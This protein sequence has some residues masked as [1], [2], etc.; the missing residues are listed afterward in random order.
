MLEGPEEKLDS[1][2]GLAMVVSSRLFMEEL[3]QRT[4]VRITDFKLGFG[5]SLGEII[6][7]MHAE[8]MSFEDTLKFV[9]KRQELFEQVQT[10][11]S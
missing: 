3:K 8:A 2:G 4:Q 1:V 10:N 6:C 9:Q 5:H 7:A 11:N